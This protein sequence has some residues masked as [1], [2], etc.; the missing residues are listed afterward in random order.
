MYLNLIQG[1]PVSKI[2]R[3]FACCTALA[4]LAACQTTPAVEQTPAI[5]GDRD[6]L[7]G[8]ELR[9]TFVGKQM[10]QIRGEWAQT[11]NRDGSI[12]GKYKSSNWTYSGSWEIR[13]DFLCAHFPGHTHYDWCGRA[14]RRTNFGFTFWNKEGGELSVV[15]VSN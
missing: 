6:Y 13:G 7:T 14:E 5:A 15:S 1:H 8:E 11:L 3:L 2:A 12:S 4:L 9:A 10:E